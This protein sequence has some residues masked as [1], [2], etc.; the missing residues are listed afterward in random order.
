[1][2]F[3]LV[4]SDFDGTLGHVP[5]EIEPET[6]A[7][8]KD[9]VARGGIFTIITGRS[10]SSI[11]EICDRYGIDAVVGCFQGARIADVKTCEYLFSSGIDY[12]MAARVIDDFTAADMPVI[13][14]VE[15]T[16]LFSQDSFYSA[17]YTYSENVIYKK[18]PDVKAAVLEMKKPASKVCA[19]CGE[20][21]TSALTARFAKKYE[22]VLTVNSG[23]KRLIE[24]IDPRF[25]KGFAVRFL[26]E[27]YGVPY[28]KIMTI[29]DSTND[30]ELV[31]GE[32]YG[33]AVG[34]ADPELKKVA[35]E[36]TVE[37]KDKPVKA[38]LEKYCR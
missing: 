34:D 2:K 28:D 29:G 25:D 12:R 26:A 16:L 37:Y 23:A 15:D 5:G 35:K 9:Y 17:M 4:I 36:V 38:L 20:D 27:K 33:V 8:I 22:G 21:E 11:K 24:V 13:A 31:K 30:L 14:W 7:A 32:W 19:V 18:V 10:F 1:M 6:V 3:D